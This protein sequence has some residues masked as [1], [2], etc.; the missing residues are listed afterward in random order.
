MKA[1]PRIDW[2]KQRARETLAELEVASVDPLRDL[3]KLCVGRGVFVTRQP[4]KGFEGM[5]L[6]QRRL[7]AVRDEISEIGRERFTI[8]H[9][10]GHWEMHPGLDQWTLCTAENIYGYRGNAEEV[11]ANCFASE[12]LMPDFL[13]TERV[14]YLSPTVETV[15]RLADHFQTSITATA[16]RMCEFSP[17]P[18]IV[19]FSSDGRLTWYRR[20]AK[21]EPYYFLRKGSE[22]DGESLARYCTASLD[23][24]MEPIEVEASA[25]F[26]E[27]R[28]NHRMTVTEESVELG[29]YGV[30]MSILTI[31]D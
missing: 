7:I 2:A 19:A 29:N 31:D 23:D 13:L 17:L 8:A 11:E 16:V 15:K 27:D 6:R 3:D 4:L 14:K 10:L 12:F 1:D 30:T 5:L 28:H 20:N 26:P 22:L 18:T 25:W 9:E 24:P 21:A